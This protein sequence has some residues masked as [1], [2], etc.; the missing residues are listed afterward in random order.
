MTLSTHRPTG[1]GAGTTTER[2]VAE[3]AVA[4]GLAAGAMVALGFSRFAYA[5]L[6]PSMRSDLDWTFTAAGGLNTANAIGY[7]VGAATA[8]WWARRLGG[9]RAFIGALS[10]SAAALLLSGLTDQYAVISAI[11]VVGGVATAVTFVLG[12]AL[13]ARVHTGGSHRRSATLVAVYMTGV[14]LGIVASGIVVPWVLARW[15][16]GAWDLGWILMG[17]IAVAL[18]VPATW[19]VHRVPPRPPGH[20]DSRGVRL[21]PLTP[22]F[23]WYVLFGAGYVSYMTFVIAHLH[24]QSFGDGE[25][26]LYFVILG[27]SSV[28]AT[29]LVWGRVVGRLSRGQGPALISVI[30]LLGVL[31]VL[32]GEGFGFAVLSAVVFGSSFMAGPTA[33]TVLARRMLPPSGW[34]TGIAML[35]VAF[36]VGQAIGPLLAGALADTEGGIELGLWLSTALLAVAAAVALTQRD[37]VP[38]PADHAAAASTSGPRALY[39]RVLVAIDGTDQRH[40]VLG[41]AAELAGHTGSAIRVVHFDADDVEPDDEALDLVQVAVADL[42]SEGITADGS[43]A[44]VPDADI[45]DAILAAAVEHEAGLIVLGANHR[46]GLGALL[47]TS[48]SDQVIQRATCAIMLVS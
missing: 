31:P 1:P 19:A 28:T 2:P 15:G 35:T 33:A 5:L 42:R 25:V 20:V 9:P 39:E 17:F 6:L 21:R 11:R 14:G 46:R 22:L 10:I 3:I 43:V 40:R 30:V 45:D 44:Q 26:A 29:L 41:A 8:A 4:L 13:A 24:E 37:V 38:Q 47:E 7:V 16:S 27:A 23:A 34:T 12:S 48:V 32:L 36:S 18:V